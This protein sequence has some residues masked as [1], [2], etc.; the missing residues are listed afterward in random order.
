MSN[1]E[2][3]PHT[4]GSKTPPPPPPPTE[5][6]RKDKSPYTNSHKKDR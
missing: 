4:N 6:V 5:Y 3:R 2:K 1:D